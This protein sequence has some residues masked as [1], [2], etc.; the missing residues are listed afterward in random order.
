MFVCALIRIMEQLP[1]IAKRLELTELEVHLADV[2]ESGEGD[3][4]Q[5]S[6]ELGDAFKGNDF[7]VIFDFRGNLVS[8]W[9]VG[10]MHSR[11]ESKVYFPVG[12]E[13]TSSPCFSH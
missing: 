4:K 2:S 6:I 7:R 13:E 12:W 9:R 11:G 10:R 3:K 8:V 1:K 5:L